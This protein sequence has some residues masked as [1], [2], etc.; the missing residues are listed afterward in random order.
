[1]CLFN[2]TTKIKRCQESKDKRLDNTDQH[3]ENQDR[4]RQEH[5]RQHQQDAEKIVFCDHITKKPDREGHRPHEVTNE[6]DNEHQ[7][8]ERKRIY[9]TDR[10]EKV[11]KVP[12]AVDPDA[13]DMRRKEYRNC[14]R[15]V[16]IDIAR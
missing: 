1:M 12:K 8:H 6:F 10:A 9:I 5:G 2:G 15:S 13:E 11:I 7:D 3:T 16:G 14:H 4:N